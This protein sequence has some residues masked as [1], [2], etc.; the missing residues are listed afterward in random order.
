MI[1]GAE[2]AAPYKVQS[3]GEFGLRWAGENEALDRLLFGAT[4]GLKNWLVD[5]GLVQPDAIDALFSDFLGQFSTILV[6]PAMPIQDAIDLARFAVETAS[7]YAK[8]GLRPET[9]GGPIEIAAITKHE[10]FKWVARKHYYTAE[11]NRE[12]SHGR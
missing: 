2:C 7:K 9:I 4:M 12:T 8:Y 5:K 11:L 3:T 6:M 1:I 10:G